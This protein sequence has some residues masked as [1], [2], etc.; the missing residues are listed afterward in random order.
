MSNLKYILIAV[1][2]GA[3]IV[4]AMYRNSSKKKTQEDADV[5]I[6][7]IEAVKKLIVTE[8]YFSELYNYKKADKYFCDLIQ[9]EKKAFLLVKGKA[10]V[11]Y[12]LTKMEY[13]VDG[14]TKTIKLIN[15]LAPQISVEPEI[16]Y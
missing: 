8:G 6:E 7:G 4:F 11:N 16:K 5:V 3:L 12:D 15:M 1:I 9:F 10:S 13:H 14:A 2:I